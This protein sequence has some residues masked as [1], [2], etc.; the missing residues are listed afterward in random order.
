M[1]FFK[2]FVVFSSL[3]SHKKVPILFYCKKRESPVIP[4]SKAITGYKPGDRV[5]ERAL[6]ELLTEKEVAELKIYLETEYD[7]QL[8]YFRPVQVDLP[9]EGME[10]IQDM[11]VFQ[12]EG[13][14]DLLQHLPQPR[15]PKAPPPSSQ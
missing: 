11:V 15:T 10:S 12:G 1:K 8:M 14:V 5:Q 9:V 2:V 4:Y 7:Y 3:Y 6:D 13:H